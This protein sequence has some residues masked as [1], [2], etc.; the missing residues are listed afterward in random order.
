MLTLYQVKQNT[1]FRC[2]YKLPGPIQNIFKTFVLIA[3]LIVCYAVYFRTDI[4]GGTYDSMVRIVKGLNSNL[5]NYL[6]TNRE[7]TNFQ[8]KIKSFSQSN[9]ANFDS[10]KFYSDCVSFN[11]PCE[12]KQLAKD[13]PALVK[14]KDQNYLI[15]KFGDAPI[16]AYEAINFDTP[17]VENRKWSFR[18]DMWTNMTY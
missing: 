6:F 12:L 8:N 3:I 1:I 9:L 5:F 16:G 17:R 10:I 4:N 15:D 18:S 7:K 11:R 14:W 13:W 2:C